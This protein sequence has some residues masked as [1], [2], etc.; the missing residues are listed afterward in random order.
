MYDVEIIGTGSYVPEN[1]VTNDDLSKI[2]DT[3]D[4][5]IRT[6]TGIKERRISLT[7]TTADLAVAAAR[8]A[9]DDAGVAA[10]ELDL[11]IVATVTPDYFFPSTACFVQNSLGASRAACFD[12]SAACTGFIFG[13]SIASQFIRTGMYQKALIIGAEALS[14]ITDWEDRGTCVLFA[15]GAGAAV[16]KRGNQGIIS[17][18]IGSDGSKGECLECPALPLKNVFIEAE[19]AKPPHAKMNGREVFK[20]AVNILPEC[21]LKI[22]ENTPYTLEDI[23]HIIPHQ[24]NLRIIDSAAKKL[25]VDQAKFYVNLPSYG[26]TSSASIPIALDEMAK[27]K[28]IHKEDLLVLVGFGGGLTY[29]AMLIK[30]T[31]GGK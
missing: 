9:L 18:V 26:N 12:I 30:W 3:S 10:E 14:K 16:I 8:R 19:E 21:I 5:W 25:Q 6:R 1:R 15:D 13:L 23:N 4:E 20:F 24:A 2:V 28:L 11:I 31:I 29:G 22:L 27:G 7:E 17:E